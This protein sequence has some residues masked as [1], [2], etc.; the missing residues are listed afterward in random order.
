MRQKPSK[1][2]AIAPEPLESEV[3]GS[4]ATRIRTH[5]LLDLRDPRNRATLALECW[6]YTGEEYW[7]LCAWR[8]A[9]KGRLAWDELCRGALGTAV[10]PPLHDETRDGSAELLGAPVAVGQ[11]IM[12]KVEVERD[13]T[14][15]VFAVTVRAP[16][17]FDFLPY[18]EELRP[19][20]ARVVARHEAELLATF[21]R[22]R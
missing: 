13:G 6:K 11:D 4:S 10:D 3:A 14:R 7:L 5:S 9:Q 16:M 19:H 2:P 18:V 17:L 15:Q 21:R 12:L 22:M 20:M 1:P 8:D